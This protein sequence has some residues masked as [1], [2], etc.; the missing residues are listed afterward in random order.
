M[1]GIVGF[2]GTV[3]ARAFLL[4]G[5]TRLEYRGYDSAG[6]A[7]AGVPG[8][9]AGEDAGTHAPLTVIRRKG[10]VAELKAA[11]ERATKADPAATSATTGIGHTRWA[12]HGVPSEENAHPHTSCD[13]RIA[14]AHN[15]IIEN[16]AQLRTTLIAQGH[17]FKSQTDSEVVAHL[18]E[19]N[20][21]VLQAS[22]T[23]APSRHPLGKDNDASGS[24]I[25]A[26]AVRATVAQLSGSFALAI[27]HANHPNIVIVTRNDSPLV[28]GSCEHGALAASDIPALI[29]YTRDV[30][31]LGDRD[32]A[33]LHANGDIEYFDPAGIPFT[34]AAYHVE[35]SFE[36]AER[37]GYPDFM[38]KEIHEQPRVIRDTI[39]NRIDPA[40]GA[41][42]FDEL[43]FTAASL[44]AIDHIHIVAC[45]TSYH[46]GLIGKDL[47]E[48]W[49]RIPVEVEPA[50][51]F[52]YR[53]PIITGTTLV[54]AISQSGETADTLE[55]VRLARTAGAHTIAL[56]N[57]VGS[58]ITQEAQTVLY[59]KAHLEIAVA[60]TKSFLA[61]VALLTLLALYFAQQ[62]TLLTTAQVRE[63]YDEM[64]QLP[65]Q[66]E[67][68]LKDVEKI[69]RAAAACV[70]ATTALFIGRGMG[71][72]TCCEGALK[73]KEISYLH[74]EAFCAG[75]IKHGPIALIDPVVATPVIAVAV[76]SATHEKMLSNIEEVLAR[77]ATVIAV[78]TQGDTRIAELTEHV[79]SIPPVSEF[80]SPLTASVPLQLLAR[81]VAIARGCDVDQPRN[82]AKS[83]TVE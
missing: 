4:N 64:A 51:E 54:I 78:A 83:V 49:A 10:K 76:Q 27:L 7:L 57:V 41:I 34:P 39:A 38:L 13:G 65:S 80:L 17:T 53:N 68:I 40:T 1:C 42:T 26:A 18:V 36:D 45:G 60:A 32:L 33:V 81:S 8:A 77:G 22:A 44:A 37:D 71:A 16:Y 79:I 56:T 55:A 21:R 19:E 50:S 67:S 30:T 43:P 63:I 28:L 11:V 75:E 82:L 52:R 25:F 31:Y 61:Q 20:Y 73:L 47:I 29:E 72:T 12:T 9:G 5:L 46:A 70:D 23:P 69:E 6:L 35:W 3:A 59:I 58:R 15:G 62:R 2:T 24:N 14:V 66:I 48:T 74:A